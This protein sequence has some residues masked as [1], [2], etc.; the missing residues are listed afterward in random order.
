MRVKYLTSTLGLVFVCY[1]RNTACDSTLLIFDK[2]IM[3]SRSLSKK[4][5]YEY[6]S[7]MTCIAV[8][9]RVNNTLSLTYTKMSL[10]IPT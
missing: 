9:E 1:D 5:E 2:A 4:G 6:K 7:S 8:R 3:D 10:K